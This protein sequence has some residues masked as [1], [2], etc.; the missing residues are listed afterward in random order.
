[1]FCSNCGTK[2]EDGAAF[3]IKCGQRV[4]PPEASAEPGEAGAEEEMAVDE[5]AVQEEAAAEEAAS[6][7]AA[8]EETSTQGTVA[9]EISAEGAAAGKPAAGKPAAGDHATD[10]AEQATTVPPNA[11]PGEAEQ[12]TT[13]LPDAQSEQ[14]TTVLAG[15]DACEETVRFP[16]V[17]DPYSGTD[18]LMAPV[19]EYYPVPEPKK[20]GLSPLAIVAIAVVVIALGAGAGLLVATHLSTN[21]AA[22]EQA[23]S[24]EAATAEAGPKTIALA[25]ASSDATSYPKVIVTIKAADEE[26][27][28]V[29]GLTS[30]DFTVSE[31]DSD[32]ATV[33]DVVSNGGGAYQLTIESAGSADATDPR[34]ATISPA[35][36]SF[37]WDSVG[38]TYTPPAKQES[39]TTVEKTVIV[40][41]QVY[42]LGQADYILPGSDSIHYSTSD[43][44]GLSDWELYIARN[45]IYAR[46]GRGFKNQD[47]ASYFSSKPW[48]TRLYSPEEFDSKVTLNNCERSNAE[49]I[50]AYEKS[51]G[52]Q[53]ISN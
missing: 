4:Q 50:L 2:L 29:L 26:G 51:I 35:G 40:T 14:P 12:P 22:S 34:S 32:N 37:T 52:S 47:L 17:S 27:E 11:T 8:T 49:M 25:V 38:F 31:K 42:P 21:V 33:S 41:P 53:Y 10:E 1:M 6:G 20:H 18:P 3:C 44:S 46:H 30:A 7:E 36:D 19:P 28:G 23:A 9:D 45:E 16:L 48:Y 24:T 13:V 5:A 39:T 43:I 15:A